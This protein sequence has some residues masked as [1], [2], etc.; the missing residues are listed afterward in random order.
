MKQLPKIREYSYIPHTSPIFLPREH[1]YSLWQHWARRFCHCFP[2]PYEFLPMSEKWIIIILFLNSKS[3]LSF[4]SLLLFW[5][6]VRPQC[7]CSQKHWPQRCGSPLFGSLH[8][9]MRGP[10][11]WTRL[12]SSPPGDDQAW[13]W[14]QHLGATLSHISPFSFTI[15]Q[16]DNYILIWILSI[17]IS[18]LIQNSLGS[19]ILFTIKPDDE[20]MRGW[21]WWVK[22]NC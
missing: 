5:R 9:A 18:W 19:W 17:F 10:R 11:S 2:S 4:G 1:F 12:T 8:W 6:G 14:E 13:T 3:L 16:A 20:R 15:N 21:G 22:R 7:H